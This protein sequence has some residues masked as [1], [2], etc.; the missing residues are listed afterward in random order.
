MALSDAGITAIIEAARDEGER[1]VRTPWALAIRRML[2]GLEGV[3]FGP[4]PASALRKLCDAGAQYGWGEWESATHSEIKSVLSQQ[5]KQS[6]RNDLRRNLER[7]T[8]PGLELERSSFDLALGALGLDS[9]KSDPGSADSIFL[10]GKPSDRLFSLFTKFP[11]LARLWTL[12]IAQWSDHVTEVLERLANDRLAL[13]RSF[14]RAEPPGK[15]INI[16]CGLS[17]SH[18]RGRTVTLVQ[19][20]HGS[21][22]Y[23]P[24]SGEGEWEW[25]SLL[26]WMNDHSS[27]PRLKAG[28]VLR[29]AGYCWMEH[30]GAAPCSG[31]TAIRRFYERVG[32]MIAAAYLLRAV[33]CHRDNV[34]LAGE[35]PVL[36][37]VDALWH[38]SPLTKTQDALSQLYR[39]GFFPSSDP[40]SLQSRSSAVGY[41]AALAARN[42]QFSPSRYHR[43]IARG[44]DKAWRCLLGTKTRRSATAKRLRRIRSRQTR[45]IYM[46][47][48]N[49]AAIRQAS[50]EPRVLRLARDRNALIAEMCTR[51]SATAAVIS[52][53]V[54]SLKRLD[55]PYF[56]RCTNEPMPRDN[57]A[58][59]NVV[60]NALKR[61]L[62]RKKGA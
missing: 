32:G 8:R 27:K 15:I 22:I 38:V 40:R 19:F 58:D 20:E 52:A 37:D 59:R 43:E 54:N 21:V 3:E 53:E 7:V 30:I 47:T 1:A 11:V 31:P 14:F 45:W 60:I 41:F 9:A 57:N 39:T 62:P 51:V 13:S 55:I 46:A 48:E 10:K 18:N 23:K 61:A 25:H 24:R 34:V 12:L 26:Q 2:K 4:R 36:V 5:A 42:K 35:Y 44:F 50:I 17:D 28:R 56:S 16:H 6:L 29:R 49:Y 33:D